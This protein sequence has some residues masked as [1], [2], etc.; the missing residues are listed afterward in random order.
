[1]KMGVDNE[2]N[3]LYNITV[4]KRSR[5]RKGGLK[6][7]AGEGVVPMGKRIVRYITCLI[8]LL[9]VLAAFCFRAK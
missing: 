2:F 8:A 1:M 3:P 7:S 6:Q 4:V 5:H 9:A